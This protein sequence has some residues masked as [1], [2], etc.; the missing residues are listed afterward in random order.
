MIKCVCQPL[1][2]VSPGIA[3]NPCAKSIPNK[4]KAGMNT[5]NPT[6]AERCNL[7]GL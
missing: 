7:N 4:P 5:R 6:P 3:S 1:L 2:T